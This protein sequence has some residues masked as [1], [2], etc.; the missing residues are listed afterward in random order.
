MCKTNEGA[1]SRQKLPMEVNV[2]VPIP[3]QLLNPTML[4]AH[5]SE[6]A[7]LGAIVLENALASNAIKQLKQE[8]F[9]DTSHRRVFAAMI[10]LFQRGSPIN[11]VLLGEE[12]KRQG[13]LESVGGVTFIT[14]LT[15]GLPHAPSVDAYAKIV[16]D[17]YLRRTYV[18]ECR[19]SAAEA[20]EEGKDFL[21][22]QDRHFKSISSLIRT[23]YDR[24]SGSRLFTEHSMSEWL[25]S[26]EL[27][28]VPRRLFG[29]FWAEGELAILFADTGAGKSALA[30]QMA[31]SIATGIPINGFP[32]EATPQLILYFDFELTDMQLQKRYAIEQRTEQRVWYAGHYMFS[33]RFRRV[34]IDSASHI[35]DQVVDWEHTL[36]NEIERQIN[37][38]GAKVIIIDNITYL[39]R[40]TEKGKFALPLMHRLNELKKQLGLSIMVL[41]HTPKRDESRALSPNDLAG[42]KI[43]SNLADTIFAIGKSSRDCNMRYLKQLKTRSTDLTH[44]AEDVAVF[45][46][47]K[48]NNFLGFEYIC[49][50]SEYDHLKVTSESEKSELIKLVGSLSRQGLTQRA[51]SKRVGISVGSVNKYVKPKDVHVV[52]DVQDVH[53]LNSVNAQPN[54]KEFAFHP[55]GA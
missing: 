18:E 6:R 13:V 28:P 51:I 27:K 46:F 43:L 1:N 50:A 55:Q 33:E 32:M 38:S 12:L 2:A 48:S 44:G 35:F 21:T 36:I 25:A 10:A 37:V 22:I 4:S 8:Y 49:T 9:H 5:E 24:E 54:G 53:T 15:Y 39:A 26:A 17:A 40:E 34:E 31:Q 47:G 29:E 30:T 42:S 3:D 45:S 20:T 19:R 23:N 7:I 41:A 16:Q 14:N 52:H 11:P